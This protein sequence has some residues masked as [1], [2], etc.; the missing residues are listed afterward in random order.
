MPT[1]TKGLVV[2]G[3]GGHAKVVAEIVNLL[4]RR[5]IVAFIDDAAHGEGTKEKFLGI[6]LISDRQD[7][8]SLLRRN[9]PEIVIA[10]GNCSTRIRLAAQAQSI[11]FKLCEPLVHPAAVVSS[12][13]T[14]GRGTVVLAG[15]VINAAAA[16]GENVIVNTC[17]SVD[18]DC[19]IEDGVHICPGARL[20]GDVSVEHGAWVGLG[21]AV[22]EKVRIGKGA[23][24]GAGAVVV[25]DIPANVLALG[26]PARVIAKAKLPSVYV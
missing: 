15:A 11:G 4:G 22:I 23:M 5:K 21:A 2:W 17:A 7:L 26:C 9:R 25:G 6:R 13:A 24:I 1:K 19:A 14:L 3:A 8:A 12:S 20:A 18:H 10:I 16:L